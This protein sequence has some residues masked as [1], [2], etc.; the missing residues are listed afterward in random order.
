MEIWPSDQK[1]SRAVIGW[2]V[3]TSGFV[4]SVQQSTD[5]RTCL[6]IHRFYD[7]EVKKASISSEFADFKQ[8]VEA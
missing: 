4:L 7:G 8:Y 3:K 1:E 5:R 2:T 6:L